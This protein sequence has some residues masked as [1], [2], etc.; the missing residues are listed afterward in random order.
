MTK[1]NFDLAVVGLGPR[2]HYALERFVQE[3]SRAGTF[4]D[5]RILLIEETEQ[6]GNGPVWDLSQPDSNWSNINDRILELPERTGISLGTASIEGFPSYHDWAAKKPTARSAENSD[7]YPPR[8]LVGSYL[9]ERFAT[10]LR[11]L[12]EHGIAKLVQERADA[13]ALTEIGACV[14]AR[15]GVKFFADQ[16]LLT[17]GHQPTQQDP[18]IESWQAEIEA[19]DALCLF[20]EPYP[21]G[22]IVDA[23]KRRTETTVAVRGYGLATIDIVRAIADAYGSFSL[24]DEQSREL[25]FAPT[26]EVAPTIIPFSL[27][28]LP[29]GPKPVNE[30]LDR[31]FAPSEKVLDALG[32]ELRDPALQARARGKALLLDAITPVIVGVFRGLEYKRDDAPSDNDALHHLVKAW[33]EDPAQGHRFCLDTAQTPIDLLKNLVQMANGSAPASLDY[34]IG[35]VWRHCHPTIYRS[36]SHGALSDD[37]LAE[38]ILTDESMKRYAFGPPIESHQQLIALYD[39]GMLDLEYLADPDITVTDRGWV[40]TSGEHHATAQIMVNA[41]LD[42]PKIADVRSPLIKGLLQ[43]G[44][45]V[46]VHDELG[47]ATTADGY[48]ISQNENALPIAVLGRLAKGTII[49]VDAILECFGER[50]RTWARS[51]AKCAVVVSKESR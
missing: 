36:L 28:G 3:L 4:K 2:G 13:V 19:R 14:T 7:H 34:C 48:V 17:V 46:P 21:V 20:D 1:S 47:V 25:T 22:P 24:R 12:V 27:D 44:L 33:I 11:P 32:R 38:I 30:Q 31:Q 50:P 18:Q 10:L 16:V 51:A 23:A 6:L 39:A 37:V 43:D 45:V 5:V 9:H 40:L 42:A 35:Q 41:V 29:M 15:S 8:N 26:E 49:G